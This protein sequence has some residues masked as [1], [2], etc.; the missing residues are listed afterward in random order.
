MKT[1]LNTVSRHKGA[2]PHPRR[3]NKITE[4]DIAFMVITGQDISGFRITK[5]KPKRDGGRDPDDSSTVELEEW[6]ARNVRDPDEDEV[7]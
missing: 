7:N 3:G 4:G 2:L 6:I 1:L 5:Y